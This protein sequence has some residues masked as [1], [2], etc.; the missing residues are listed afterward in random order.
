[1]FRSIIFRILHNTIPSTIVLGHRGGSPRALIFLNFF[2][3]KLCI[4][5][6][7]G[8]NLCNC[9]TLVHNSFQVEVEFHSFQETSG[10]SLGI[11]QAMK[12]NLLLCLLTDSLRN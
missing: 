9:I 2:K 7:K 5:K 1:M 8:I 11:I 4:F 3:D 10:Q 12:V 6:R